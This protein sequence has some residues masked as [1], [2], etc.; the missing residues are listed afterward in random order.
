MLLKEDH[1]LSGGVVNGA[2]YFICVYSTIN[3]EYN[4]KKKMRNL[5]DNVTALAGYKLNKKKR[6]LAGEL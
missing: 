6:Y 2:C 1:F 4:K 3:L 5:F